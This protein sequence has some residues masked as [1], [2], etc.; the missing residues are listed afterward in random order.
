MILI[1]ILALLLS[2]A[3]GT[4]PQNATGT[5]SLNTTVRRSGPVAN[6]SVLLVM[7]ENPIDVPAT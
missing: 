5:S 3:I 6:L 4:A 7:S 1:A 2:S